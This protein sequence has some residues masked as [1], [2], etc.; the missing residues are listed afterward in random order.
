MKKINTVTGPNEARKRTRFDPSIS[1]GSTIKKQPPIALTLAFINCQTASLQENVDNTLNKHVTKHV[2]YHQYIRKKSKQ[3]NRFTN[4]HDLIT[5]SSIID[6]KFHVPQ[7]SEECED[8]VAL[9]EDTYWIINEY[10]KPSKK[11]AVKEIILELDTS[12]L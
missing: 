1:Q 5:K 4:N 2:T 9:T 3:F 7:V 12:L 8:I 10:K 6:L 11:K